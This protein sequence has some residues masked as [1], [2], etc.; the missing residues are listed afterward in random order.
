MCYI[1]TIVMAN[2]LDNKAVE[3]IEAF[4]KCKIEIFI[5]TY[6]EIKETIERFYAQEKAP[7]NEGDLNA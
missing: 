5:A 7:K 2:P 6:K 4:A 3:E 1:L